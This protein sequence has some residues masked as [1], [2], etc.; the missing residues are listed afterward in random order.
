[1]REPY[2]E[3]K[4][5]NCQTNKLK[6]GWRP[7]TKTNWPCQSSDFW[8]EVPQ[9]SRPY[10]TVSFE[11]PQLQGPGSHIYMPQEQVGPVIPLGTG[12]PFVAPYDLQGYGGGILTRLHM[13]MLCVS[14]SKVIV[15]PTVSRPVR[16]GVWHPSGT[17]DQIS[18]S[19]F[20]YFWTVTGLL[21]CGALSD[22]RTGL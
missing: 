7:S 8:V 19:L 10:F 16:L 11:T 21:M 2:T 6:S 1:M 13:G 5:S 12:F 22:E 9:N 4:E 18:P 17:R 15:R 20:V 3:K 14:K